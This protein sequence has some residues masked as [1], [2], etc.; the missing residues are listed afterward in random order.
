MLS[1]FVMVAYGVKPF[2]KSPCV[3]DNPLSCSVWIDSHIY[4]FRLGP[5]FT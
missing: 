3:M 5:D 4:M 2:E 1:S